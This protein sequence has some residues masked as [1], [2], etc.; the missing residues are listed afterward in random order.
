MYYYCSYVD[1]F[2][3]S[4]KKY[5]LKPKKDGPLRNAKQK[6]DSQS[7]ILIDLLLI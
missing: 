1:S 4:N 2:F 3:I 7:F 6:F 5:F